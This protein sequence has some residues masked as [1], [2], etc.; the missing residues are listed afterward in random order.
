MDGK[1]LPDLPRPALE[2][3]AQPLRVFQDVAGF[4]A[5]QRLCQELHVLDPRR[6]VVDAHHAA[7]KGVGRSA[8]ARTPLLSG[9]EGL[10]GR[11]ARETVT[12]RACAAVPVVRERLQPT[13]AGSRC[14]LSADVR[15]ARP[16]CPS[17]T[18]PRHVSKHASRPHH[19]SRRS[20]KTPRLARLRPA[21]LCCQCWG[22]QLGRGV[23]DLESREYG[24][25]SE[26]E[27]GTARGRLQVMILLCT[28]FTPR[29]LAPGIIGQ[30]W[31]AHMYRLVRAL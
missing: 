23:G 4:V 7:K 3:G 28:L 20:R 19:R 15:S 5:L 27:G 21:R 12:G 24:Q 31:W 16:R 6:H 10:S 25:P 11:P 13:L 2:V 1:E 30:D 14:V 26:Q 8:F 17:R 22:L 18:G 9:C 29:P